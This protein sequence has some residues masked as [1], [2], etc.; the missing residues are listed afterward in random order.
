MTAIFQHQRQLV[1][2]LSQPCQGTFRPNRTVGSREPTGGT[3]DIYSAVLFEY[4]TLV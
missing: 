3:E 4:A 2:R 1:K